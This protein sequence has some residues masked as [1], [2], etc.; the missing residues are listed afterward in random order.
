[1][2]RKF[3]HQRIQAKND[4]SGY[5]FVGMANVANFR[6]V[7]DDVTMPGAFASDLRERGSV[8]PLLW[9]HDPN[10]PIGKV[11]LADTA[12]GLTVIE[13]KLTR[14]VQR[15]E[16]LRA[17]L[18]DKVIDS[19]SVGYDALVAKKGKG[20][21]RELHECKLWEVSLVLWPA[22]VLSRVTEVRNDP[23]ALAA[24]SHAMRGM[25][26]SIQS[27]KDRDDAR[28]LRE[29]VIGLKV[30]KIEGLLAQLAQL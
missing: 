27:A 5:T 20:G 21:V 24:L 6:D 12:K 4:G 18:L 15:A 30:T 10:N 9:N 29:A 23:R 16:E 7:Q 8:R 3:F 28:Q 14:G 13:G 26:L 2:E 25:R 19:M 22:N 1:M 17:L 11:T